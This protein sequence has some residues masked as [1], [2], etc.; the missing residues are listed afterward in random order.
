MLFFHRLLSTSTLP[1]I[2]LCISALI[3]IQNAYEIKAFYYLVVILLLKSFI[4]GICK[5][6]QPPISVKTLHPLYLF[7]SICSIITITSL[8]NP[9][10]R[11]EFIYTI[12]MRKH[13]C[14]NTIVDCC[15]LVDN[16]LLYSN[17]KMYTNKLIIRKLNTIDNNGSPIIVKYQCRQCGFNALQ[18][19]KA[20]NS[21]TSN[22]QQYYKKFY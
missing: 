13:Y 22:F 1:I 7:L 3:S 17:L 9:L 2:Q 19:I 21:I 8:L 14:T 10:I 20:G 6:F 11:Y 15:Q 18:T 12:I 16:S 5:Q 4:T